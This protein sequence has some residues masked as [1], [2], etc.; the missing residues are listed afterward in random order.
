VTAAAVTVAG[1]VTNEHLMRAELMTNPAAVR[2]FGDPCTTAG[3][4]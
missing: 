2:R 4:Y 3:S 1:D